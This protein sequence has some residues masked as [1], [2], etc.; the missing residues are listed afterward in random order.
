[1]GLSKKI[2]LTC[3]LL[4]GFINLY[5]QE[6]LINELMS[7][8]STNIKDEDGDNSDWIELYNNSTSEINLE[9]Y[10]LSDDIAELNKWSFPNI[11]LK[12]HQHL[13]IFASD[14]D[15]KKFVLDWNTIINKGGDWKYA[16]G[17]VEPP[18]NWNKAEY[19]ASG[20]LTGPTGIGYGDGDD[21]TIISSTI[22]LYARKIFNVNNLDEVEAAILHIDYDDAFVAYLNG[23]E[24]TRNNIGTVGIPPAFDQPAISAKEAVM[25]TGGKPEAYD[26]KNAKSLLV[27]G[28]NV[29]AV[30]V[31]NTENSSDLSFIPFLTLGFNTI[32]PNS[33]VPE[34]L[35]VPNFYLHTNFKIS[36]GGETIILT[37]SSG[38]IL[39]SIYSGGIP[40]NSSYGRQ[41]DGSTNWTIF[42]HPTPGFENDTT[43]SLEA[44]EPPNFSIQGGLYHQSINVTLSSNSSNAKIYY[45]LAGSI[46]NES[47]TLYST[48]LSFNSTTVVRAIS[49]EDNFA[50]SKII[51]QTYF[52]DVISA[53]PII[54]ISTDP[55]NFF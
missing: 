3:F 48:P 32:Q 11:N 17:N 44:S 40:A 2:I 28:T 34:I 47:S 22:S 18:S 16:L 27:N 43:Q 39:D 25:Y 53:L 24:I 37:N 6:V 35:D 26:I 7:S 49:L 19:D 36:A 52:I 33:E 29:L 8:N 5:S 15:R 4:F 45:T 10:S 9:N 30:Q 21:S 50:P 14:K 13:L 23:V 51:T 38:E 12:G 46:P 54:S 42:S 1:M 31:H 55:E 20:W 41:P